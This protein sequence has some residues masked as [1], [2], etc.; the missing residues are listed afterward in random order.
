MRTTKPRFKVQ[1]LGGSDVEFYIPLAMAQECYHQGQC[2]EACL[3]YARM[4]HRQL[5]R[6]PDTFYRECLKS[7]GVEAIDE[8]TTETLHTYAIWLAAGNV[9]EDFARPSDG[10]RPSCWTSLS[11][12]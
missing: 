10:H 9:V 8:M 6:V 2:E 12:Y 1:P 7:Y 4:C 3:F 5:A 11:N